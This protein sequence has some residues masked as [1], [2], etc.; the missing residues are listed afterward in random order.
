MRVSKLINRFPIIMIF[1]LVLINLTGCGSDVPDTRKKKDD[2]KPIDFEAREFLKAKG[3]NIKL[4]TATSFFYTNT[5]TLQKNGVKV[6]EVTYFENG[7]VH[8][9]IRY[10]SNGYIDMKYTYEYDDENNVI[11]LKTENFNG[12]VYYE[13]KSE[14]E[15]G[16][17]IS[18]Y[19]FELENK[20][21]VNISYKYSESGE[22]IE[23][24]TKN[25][26]GDLVSKVEYEYKPDKS[27]RA[28][29]Y[30]KDGRAQKIVTSFFD[31]EKKKIKQINE[32]PSLTSDTI[33]YVYDERKNVLVFDE[34]YFMQKYAF[35][36]ND[37]MTAQEW[38]SKGIDKQGT[39]RFKYDPRG[40]VIERVRYDSFDEPAIY[41]KYEYE[42]YK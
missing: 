16:Y 29:T 15:N 28:A 23:E 17:E 12:T 24:I 2:S 30:D 10:A 1:V 40:L 22:L 33:K 3:K 18:R 31:S 38:Y 13:R 21:E 4:R 32:H 8:E 35:D 34:G 42:F 7:N 6:E 27:V 25:K 37:N 11:S 26:D 39:I 41:T 5:N 14:F 9:V 36:E 19:E 20:K